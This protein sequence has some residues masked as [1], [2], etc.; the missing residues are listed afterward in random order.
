MLRAQLFDKVSK[1]NNT[2]KGTSV[3]TKFSMQSIL[4]KPPSSS[5]PKLYSV[6]PLP[7]SKVIPKVGESDALSKQVTLNSAPSSRE[8]T[9]VNNERYVNGMKSRK[10]NQSSNVS[11]STNQKKHKENVK[12]LKKSV[13]KESL[14]SPRPSKPRTYLRWLPTRRIFDLCEKITASSNTESLR[15][16]KGPIHVSIHLL[17]SKSV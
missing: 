15:D 11:K 10:K 14:A 16:S 9:V 1:Q 4:G 6:T 13:S 3:D 2:T 5:G 7:K 17:F 8:S 12:K